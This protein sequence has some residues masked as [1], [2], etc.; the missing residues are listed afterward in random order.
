MLF[1][2]V[3]DHVGHYA[4]FFDVR[5]TVVFVFYGEVALFG[6]F[7]VADFAIAIGSELVGGFASIFCGFGNHFRLYVVELSEVVGDV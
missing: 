4:N 1:F 5:G 3:V 2:E 6:R 7:D